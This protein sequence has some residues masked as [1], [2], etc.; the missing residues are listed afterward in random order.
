HKS[1]LW[2]YLRK[3]G[4]S[5]FKTLADLIT[6]HGSSV[7]DV[8]CGEALVLKYLPKDFKYTGID[9]SDFIITK[10]Y[11]K[12][13]RNYLS[14]IVSDMYK[15]NVT[16]WYDIILF[17]G[18]FTIL[19]KTEILDLVRLYAAKYKPNY[20]LIAD[21]KKVDLSLVEKN[22]QV[23]GK[24]NYYFPL[25]KKPLPAGTPEQINNRQILLIKV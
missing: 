18:T 24:T 20:I 6:S 3:N 8:G 5:Y 16:G 19:H 2:F 17:A 13:P 4:K 25:I 10:N 7:L 22:F 21:L 12:Y 23:V 15:P 9:L 14:F 1:D 11:Q